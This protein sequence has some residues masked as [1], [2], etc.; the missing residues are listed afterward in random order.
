VVVKAAHLDSMTH[1][2]FLQ[3]LRYTYAKTRESS[4]CS[5]SVVP[6]PKDVTDASQELDSTLPPL[7]A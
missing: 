4:P 7:L 2:E 6:L 1:P 3:R 5:D